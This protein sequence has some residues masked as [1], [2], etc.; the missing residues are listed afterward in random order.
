[1]SVTT[2][3]V[4]NAFRNTI[5]SVSITAILALTIAL[6][7]VML[8]S[9]KAVQARIDDVKASVGN[10]ITVT[11]AG[12]RGFQ[13]GGEP[14]TAADIAKIRGTA[15]VK[16][17]TST[18]E[19]RWIT[20]GQ[21]APT[22]PDGSSDTAGTTNLQS[23]IDPGSLGNRFGNNGNNEN[24][25]ST[26]GSFPQGNFVLPITVTGTTAPGS[27]TVSGVNSFKLTA[28][29]TI[30]G[31]SNEYVALVG[32]ALATKN[33]LSVGSTFIAYGQT[34]TV[35]GIYDT[36][37]AFSNAGVIMPLPALQK[38]SSQT[39]D[40]TSAIVTVDSVD[41]LDA[42]VSALEKKLGNSADVVSDAS[43]SAD[44]LSSLDNVKTIATYSLVGAL[45]AGSVIIFLSM[46]MIVR[47]RRRE[48]GV[49]KAIGSS[50]AKISWQF[51]TEALTLTGMAAV[52]GVLVGVIL[53]N[54]VLD[55]LVSSSSNSANG[56][57]FTAGPGS[58]PG[59]AGGGPVRIGG[60][61]TR[62]FTQ[63]GDVLSN[64]QAHVGVS[65]LLYGLLAAVLIAVVGTAFPSWLIAKVRPAE[66]MRTE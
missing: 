8:L 56:P 14:L 30:D 4:K 21:T 17:E 6:A 54:P 55:A 37:N 28:G 7:L 9:L 29:E 12:A 59:G 10:T 53:S 46:L 58:G 61:I 33:N 63:F 45:V 18:L 65:I 60:G 44:T 48:I 47:E 52:V 41:H 15:H 19:D 25:Q 24:G 43:A 11:P 20:E 22:R 42:T 32:K 51:V 35:K 16:S 1:M 27:T 36:G 13:G 2:R 50:N 34:I 57:T 23:A 5:R 64:V 26:N 39:G 62:G 49:L 66:V 31:S 3:G 40:V 38:L